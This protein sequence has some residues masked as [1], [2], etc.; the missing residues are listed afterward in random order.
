MRS[1]KI[2]IVL[3]ASFVLLTGCIRAATGNSAQAT[4]DPLYTQ[5]AAIAQT[6]TA[7]AGQGI[8]LV[9]SVVATERPGHPPP[10]RP[11]HQAPKRLRHPARLSCQPTHRRPRT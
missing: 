1:A 7:A 6:A 9:T 11:R 2:V 3:T 4:L 5:Q 10:S 8:I